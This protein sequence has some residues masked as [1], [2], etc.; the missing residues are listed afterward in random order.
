MKTMELPPNHKR[1]I[2]ATAKTIE[3]ELNDLEILFSSPKNDSSIRKIIPTFSDE[4]RKYLI[5]KKW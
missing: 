4:E 1:V 5:E 3:E 2:S